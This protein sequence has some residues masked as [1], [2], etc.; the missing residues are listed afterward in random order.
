MPVNQLAPAP[1]PPLAQATRRIGSSAIRDLLAVAERPDVISL[2][3]GLPIAER[4]PVHAIR[5]ASEHVLT[6]DPTGALQYAATVGYEPLR[7]WVAERNGAAPD[8][9][10][11]THGSQQALELLVRTLVDPGTTVAL[12]DPAYIGAVQAFRLSGAELL[13][14]PRDGDGMRVDVLAERL[15]AGARPA[16][17]YVVSDID[18]PSGTTLPDDRRRALAALADR[19]GFWIVDDDPYGEL[20]WSGERP[21]PLR[22]LSDRV[23]TLGTTSKVLAPGL[24]VGW[25]VAPAAIVDEVVVLKQAVDLQTATFAQRIA[26]RLFSQPEFLDPHLEGVRSAYRVQAEALSAALR[27][28]LGERIAFAEPHGGMFL[29]ARVEDVDARRLLGFALE[30]GTAFVPGIE[31]AVDPRLATPDRLRLSF[32]TATPSD[33]HEAASRLALAVQDH[34]RR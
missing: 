16:L 30:R 18:N 31:F 2:A 32:A 24:R 11:I 4:F 5:E 29:W 8:E 26:H 19:Y 1:L 6:E 13:G 10:V 15:A 34:D 23:I 9:V 22:A 25:A 27:L 33:L 17:V 14:I 20:R 3:G 28:E 21:R 7:A 12:T